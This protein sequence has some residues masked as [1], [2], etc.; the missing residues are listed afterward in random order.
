MRFDVCLY[1]LL[2][3]GGCFGVRVFGWVTCLVLFEG[4]GVAFIADWWV[5]FACGWVDWICLGLVRGVW[6]L[7]GLGVGVVG[8]DF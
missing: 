6:W 5:G 8:C 7:F 3:G 1:G 4:V 2:P